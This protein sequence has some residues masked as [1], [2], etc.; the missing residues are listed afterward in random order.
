MELIIDQLTVGHDND[1][2]IVKRDVDQNPTLQ[3]KYQTSPIPVF[4]LLKDSESIV[5]FIGGHPKNQLRDEIST[6]LV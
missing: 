1:L 4:H 2:K 6:T 3:M 5:E